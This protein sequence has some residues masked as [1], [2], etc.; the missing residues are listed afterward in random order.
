MILILSQNDDGSTMDVMKWVH[1]LGCRCL[2][3]NVEDRNVYI[4]AV[5]VA[6]NQVIIRV[7]DTRVDL[8][9]D[10]S[11]VWM[12]RG[13]LPFNFP[14]LPPKGFYRKV[15]RTEAATE[16]LIDHLNTEI[17]DLVSYV[18]ET[19][20]HKCIGG[21]G[22]GRVNKL[23]VLKYAHELGIAIPDSQ[24][25]MRSSLLRERLAEGAYITKAISDTFCA[26]T[27]H[28]GYTT[29]TEALT[30]GVDAPLGEAMFPSLIQS[31]VAKDVELRIFYW[32]GEVYAM[33]IFSQNDAQT[34]VDFRVYNRE[35][36]NRFVPYRLPETEAAKLGRLMDRLGL[37]TG[38]IDMIRDHEGRYVFLE[39]NPVGQF[40]MVSVPC[41]YQLERRI[42]ET[43]VEY[44]RA[45]NAKSHDEI[46]ENQAVPTPV[47]TAAP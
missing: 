43:L 23:T 41:G 3:I 11:V 29:Y 46:P 35:R 39:V 8:D 16:A 44:E 26:E 17:V 31:Q 42:A 25:L 19:F 7:G 10:V 18:H 21:Y 45:F 4:E 30:P 28:I 20:A 33:A 9:R 22:R 24:V 37:K 32:F 6:R 47:P 36:P 27:S 14:F 38:S 13:H 15:F 34:A 2:R 5:D 1:H 40:G 12:R